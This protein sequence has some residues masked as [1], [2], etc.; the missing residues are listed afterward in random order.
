MKLLLDEM[1]TAEIARQLRRR[2][3]DVTA[4]QEQ[5]RLISLQDVNLFAFA[6]RQ[7]RV[8]V[9]ENVSD[10]LGLDAQ[11]RADGQRHVG[12]ILT[13]NRQFSRR[14]GAGIGRMVRALEAW[15]AE[16]PGDAQPDS[17]LWWL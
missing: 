11:Y 17:Q 9:T 2:G 10:F 13:T 1:F 15:L 8:L 4:V 5:E 7:R 6:Q 3:H 12:L 14:G 16:H